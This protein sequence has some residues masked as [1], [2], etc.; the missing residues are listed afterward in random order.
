LSGALPG[1][2]MESANESW[3]ATIRTPRVQFA[4]A[5]VHSTICSQA[6]K[7]GLMTPIPIGQLAIR[8]SYLKAIGALRETRAAA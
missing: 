3:W 8:N 7:A 5:G 6:C 4:N 1:V 2:S